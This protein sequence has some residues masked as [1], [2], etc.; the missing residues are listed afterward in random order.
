AWYRAGEEGKAARL[1]RQH[2]WDLLISEDPALPP[3]FWQIAY[4]F[5]FGDRGQSLSLP[6]HLDPR[7]VAA[8]IS[9]ESLWEP[10]IRSPA[11]AIGLMQIM[12]RTGKRLAQELGIDFPSADVLYDP[13]IN[14]SIGVY[15]LRQ[16]LTRFHNRIVPAIASYN[17]GE[18]RVAKWWERWHGLEEDE[19]IT[20]IPFWETRRYVQK[21]LAYY[22]IYQRLYPL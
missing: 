1:L 12:P 18:W 10:D 19:F 7:L 6:P 22:Q 14:L 9:A 20:N 13:H 4:P 11:G 16:L 17:A 3:L 2:F 21:V 5:P 8:I 15:Y